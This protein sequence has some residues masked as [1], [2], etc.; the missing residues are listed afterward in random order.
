MVGLPSVAK[1]SNHSFTVTTAQ[2]L[3]LTLNDFQIPAAF[4][5]L[6]VAVT[7][8]D[9][10]V[11]SATVD[12]TTHS[13]TLAIPAA[14]GNY[15]LH[16]IGTPDASQ[17]RGSFGVC[18]APA[19]SATSCV[20]DYSFSGDI[21]TPSTS[22]TTGNST[23]NTNFTST[24]AGTYTVTVTDDAFP[25]ALQAIAGGISLGSTPISSIPSAG[26]TQV[27]LAAGTNYQLI[28]QAVASSTTLAGLYGVQITDPTGAAVFNRTLPV[29]T[30]TASTIV[31]N[32]TAR[33]LS[34]GLTDY[35]YPAALASVGVV[36]TGGST[37]L[38]T[39]AAPGALNNFNAPAGS[40]EIWQFAAAGAQPGVYNVDLSVYQAAGN[41]ATL[42]SATQVVN[43]P[44]TSGAAG[45]AF[46]A[47][48]PSAGTYNLV[49]NDFKFPLAFASVT[50]TVAQ[51][52]TVLAQN[53][54][55]D[56]TAAAGPVVLLV[57]ATPP[58]SG[59]GIFGV[60][61]QT[62]GTS[63]QILLDKTQAVGGVFNTQTIDFGASGGYDMT[64][65]DL[66]F[67]AAFQDLA[68]VLSRG[69]QVLGK[70]YQSGTFS[71]PVT[72]A[73]YVLTFVAT[74][75]SQNYGLYS[76]RMASSVPKV[77]FTAGAAAVTV[78]QTVQFTWST[79]DAT[80]CKAS[81]S[82]AW[83]GSEATSGTTAVVVSA[84]TTFTL[85]CT[86]PGGSAAQSVTV[87][88]TPAPAKSGGGGG[89]SLDWWMLAGLG[90]WVL[91][92]S[93]LGL[94]VALPGHARCASIP[95]AS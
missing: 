68:V 70:I 72:P 87:T 80:A 43:P 6:Q 17:G 91:V 50:G 58:Q 28:L 27:M 79:V 29:G 30:M 14:A 5:S 88:A 42:Y 82:S 65:A 11:G 53:A 44:S 47:T 41:G 77:T 64:L 26:T 46:V 93:L 71:L 1:P 83:T 9:T 49:V 92:S 62:S 78:D 34:L 36:V 89:G 69:S 60:T 37:A 16:V 32:T 48:L 7:L 31:D 2:A 8:G 10:V 3:T 51:N 15:A 23:L 20:S 35:G 55:G 52:G 75:S 81:G 25:T 95:T 40:L 74:P 57:N 39:L 54:S 66:G 63:P 22:S 85:T 59:N 56:F 13:G 4:T 19:A 67:P 12:A 38:A 45:Y 21:Q 76:I 90:L 61:I 94:G 33:S 86:G 84:T 18:V 73:Q 24:V